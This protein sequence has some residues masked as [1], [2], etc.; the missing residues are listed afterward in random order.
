MKNIVS[1]RM[2][3][4]QANELLNKFEACGFSNKNA[5]R[6]IDDSSSGLAAQ[7][8]QLVQVNV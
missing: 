7:I 6:V 1:Q 4:G 3:R 2:S 5:Q 8:V